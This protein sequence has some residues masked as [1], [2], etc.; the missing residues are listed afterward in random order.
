MREYTREYIVI[1]VEETLS[2]NNYLF[3]VRLAVSALNH[4]PVL[5]LL[6]PVFLELDLIQVGLHLS[7]PR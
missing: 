7:N 3:E 4:L 6:A 2:L 5:L 1:L